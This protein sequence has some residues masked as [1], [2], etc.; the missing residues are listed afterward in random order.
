MAGRRSWEQ[1][2]ADLFEDLEQQAEALAQAERAAEVADRARAEYRGVG[3]VERLRASLGR[4]VRLRIR[5]VGTLAGVVR[6]TASDGL[7]LADPTAARGGEWLIPLTAVE[8]VAG[9]S[10]AA[11]APDAWGVVAR[12]GWAASVRRLAEDQ[13]P[14][15]LVR[16]DGSAVATTLHRVGADFVEHRPH[17]RP[18]D[19]LLTATAAIAAIR[20]D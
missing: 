19:P 2:V 7:L 1:S 10:D 16:V 13:E 3:L 12:L 11:V 14:C 15:V 18:D 20:S 8:E 6:R 9:A 17:D 4:P 5:G